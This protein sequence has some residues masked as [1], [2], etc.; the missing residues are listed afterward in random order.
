MTPTQTSKNFTHTQ[1]RPKR[2]EAYISNHTSQFKNRKNAKINMY[3][4]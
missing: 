1:P 2:F 4:Y 3:F